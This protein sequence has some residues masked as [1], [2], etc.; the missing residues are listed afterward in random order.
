MERGAAG[1]L[2]ARPPE[3]ETRQPPSTLASGAAGDA[4]RPERVQ[5]QT[6]ASPT[7]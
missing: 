4:G 3:V 7:P 5:P 2:E 6:S 1:R